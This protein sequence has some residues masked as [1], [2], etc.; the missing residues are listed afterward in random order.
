M[1]ESSQNTR[2]QLSDD[3]FVEADEA[4]NEAVLALDLIYEKI[5]H[6]RCS[7]EVLKAVALVLTILCCY[8]S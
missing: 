4:Y 2:D 7:A 3:V 1:E 6:G 5:S 8:G